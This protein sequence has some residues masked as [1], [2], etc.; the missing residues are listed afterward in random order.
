[1]ATARKTSVAQGEAAATPATEK[2]AAAPRTSRRAKPP[3]E[4][5]PVPTPPVV[6]APAPVPPVAPTSPASPATQPVA[7]KRKK[8]SKAFSRP[9][10][11]VLRQKSAQV[12]A[13]ETQEFAI[14]RDGFTFP[15]NEHEHL[16]RI[17]KELAEQGVVVKKSELIRVALMLLR[18][19]PVSK[20]KASLDKLPKIQ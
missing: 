19:C 20:L 12:A 14:V 4:T 7:K 1:M 9:L 15:K 13:P 5:P 16:V 18:A 2:A 3:A 6:A 17:K 11:K 8:L 10:D